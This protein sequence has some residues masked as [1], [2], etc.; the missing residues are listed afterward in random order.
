MKGHARLQSN[1]LHRTNSPVCPQKLKF[2]S[3]V[4]NILP[5]THLFRIFCSIN[6]A[7]LLEN[8]DLVGGEGVPSYPVQTGGIPDKTDRE[9][10]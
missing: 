1:V 7:Y 3:F 10:S 9:H 4:F 2:K 5:A 6:Q 8:K